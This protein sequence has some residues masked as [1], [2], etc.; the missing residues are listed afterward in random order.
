VG[1]LEI[2]IAGGVLIAIAGYG[3]IAVVASDGAIADAARSPLIE[4]LGWL[5]LPWCVACIASGGAMVAGPIAWRRTVLTRLTGVAILLAGFTVATA[6]RE[7][8]Q[9]TEH[10]LGAAT[11]SGV[12]GGSLHGAVQSVF[13]SNG[14]TI[15]SMLATLTGAV[16]LA[17]IPR[18]WWRQLGQWATLGAIWAATK[19]AH[20]AVRGGSVGARAVG[21]AVVQVAVRT[22][23]ASVAIVIVSGR[24][25]RHL[26]Q[27]FTTAR[28]T[29]S[30]SGETADAWHDG[31]ST[32]ITE[33]APLRV[34]RPVDNPPRPVSSR[35]REGSAQPQT[36]ASAPPANEMRAVR[37]IRGDPHREP[38]VPQ[39]GSLSRP[40]AFATWH[41]PSVTMLS[42]SAAQQ[43]GDAEI[44]EKASTIERTLRSFN[45][46]VTVREA[47]VG[48]TVTQF[49]LVPGEGV[50]VKAIKR[51]EYDLQLRLT[52]K[53]LRIELPVPGR[54]FVGIEIPND[55]AASV[56]LREIL[57]SRE[58]SDH[59]GRLRVGLGRDV[60]GRPRVGDLARMPHVLIA[61]QTGAGKSVCLNT[62]VASLLCFCRPDELNLLMIDPKQ[63]ELAEYEGIPHLRYPVVTD[64][65]E[66]GKLLLWVC[67]EMERRYTLL[68]QAGYRHLDAYN[69][70]LEAAGASVSTVTAQK[71]R[72]GNSAPQSL[73]YIVLI[74][75]EL[76]DLMMFAPDD[77][78]PAICRLTAKARAVGIHLVVATQ[79]PSVN[80]VTGLIKA[81]IP[82]RVAFAVASQ[83]DSRVI[84]D[85]GGAEALLGKGDML[86]LPYDQGRPVRVQGAWV[87][88][89]ELSALVKHWKA[90]GSPN[91]VSK[92]EIDSL[93]LR[94][95]EAAAVKDH[96]KSALV[97][98]A[99]EAMRST[100]SVSVSFLQR[101]LGIGYPKAAKL[102]DDLE[103]AGHVELDE[104]TGRT[105]R[106]IDRG[107]APDDAEDVV[108]PV[109]IGR[110]GRIGRR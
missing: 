88:D 47:R 53:T 110:R 28:P 106:V 84:L 21:K 69:R 94:D 62:I 64:L 56:G 8:V 6:P 58:F 78:E 44:A 105:Y 63:V 37:A 65:A 9:A 76:A 81:N 70:S 23:T 87:S 86:Y 91:Y 60:D 90:Q 108:K 89:G 50:P 93:A 109:V 77:V 39:S 74:I 49:S 97:E 55:R 29:R 22:G 98:R 101:K 41:L 46:P 48:P 33:T 7:P 18:P 19:G 59:T 92:A 43:L 10:I 85:T 24:L 14:A 40:D 45:I 100:N 20:L 57:E 96:A 71:V 38:T 104:T 34:R 27:T 25:V 4:A 103:D 16:L 72:E 67:D 11:G 51:F 79:R 31:H 102:M 3:A 73:P 52:A 95:E 99:L 17:G 5:A 42:E 15:V 66:A 82:S 75:D 107:G 83:T 1:V 12:I 35:V 36:A 13:G 54:P 32:A 2:R 61:G 68:S 80:V 30:P 26:W